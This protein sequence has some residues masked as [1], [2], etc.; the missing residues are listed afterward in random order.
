MF[1]HMSALPIAWLA[2]IGL[3]IAM[4]VILDGFTLGIGILFSFFKGSEE[5]D[6]MMGAASPVWDGN[7][8]WMILAGAGLYGAFPLVYATVLPA[9]YLPL[10]LM[11][12]ALIFR[13]IAFEFRAKS[14]RYRHMFDMAF[15]GGALVATFAEGVVLGGII[16]GLNVDL[17]QR[18]FAGGV[19]DWMTPFSVFTGLALVFGYALLGASWMVVKTEGALQ[20]RAYFFVRPLCLLVLLSMAV[21]AIWTPIYNEQVLER[22]S[23]VPGAVMMAVLA[24][25]AIALCLSI[26]SGIN[27][28]KERSIFVKVIGLFL[29]GLAGLLV[30]FFPVIIPPYVTIFQAASSEKSQ[31]F[32]IIGYLVIIPLVLGY[33]AY[34]YYVFR[35]KVRI[36]NLSHY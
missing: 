30:S 4:Y 12:L 35:G 24:I 36:E 31:F 33:T 13:G 20:R 32:L 9:L 29:V 11:L 23:T 14:T 7:Q 34:S 19:L 27:K 5:R 6:V 15:S 10:V 3:A 22:W 2:I 18:H 25:I 26:I 21:V 17:D 1:E 8:T 16:H 28:R